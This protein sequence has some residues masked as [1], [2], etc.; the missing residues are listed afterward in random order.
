MSLA[1]FRSEVAECRAWIRRLDAGS[2]Q[3][4]AEAALPGWW[5]VVLPLLLPLYAGIA[6]AT[7]FRDSLE[8]WAALLPWWWLM[9][10]GRLFAP[11]I[12][13]EWEALLLPSRRSWMVGR[14]SLRFPALLWLGICTVLYALLLGL[15]ETPRPE[16]LCWPVALS[17]LLSPFLLTALVGWISVASRAFGGVSPLVPLIALSVAA[18]FFAGAGALLL[19]RRTSE[20]LLASGLL[21]AFGSVILLLGLPSLR[22]LLHLPGGK[23]TLRRR[24]GRLGS[25]LVGLLPIAAVAAQAALIMGA[26]FVVLRGETPRHWVFEVGPLILLVSGTVV[27]ALHTLHLLPSIDLGAEPTLAETPARAASSGGAKRSPLL[28]VY[29]GG[30]LL[31]TAW[32]L[33]RGRWRLLQHPRLVFLPKLLWEFRGVA[34]GF[35]AVGAAS[36]AGGMEWYYGLPA[37]W[38]AGVFAMVVPSPLAL[39]ASRRLHLLGA[40]YADLARYNLRWGLFLAVLPAALGGSV[41]LL[42]PWEG[43]PLEAR[44][45][46]LL[47]LTAFLACRQGPAVPWLNKDSS[48]AGGKATLGFSAAWVVL[49]FLDAP[50]ALLLGG[51]AA[52]LLALVAVARDL[53]DP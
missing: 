49:W 45:G 47:A 15:R 28:P 1:V 2:P 29:P 11:G 32:S 53:R 24:L 27:A 5:E 21:A 22:R 25:L 35:I 31:R 40:D 39:P 33:Y 36:A 10:G 23:S 19:Y 18:A 16:S 9:T 48:T 34:C 14:W 41:L 44:T 4:R 52:F 43:V 6:L 42:L 51:A 38:M 26:R 17:F 12:P 50:L 8:I 46:G 7:E 20:A 37:L 13:T 30:G 3:T